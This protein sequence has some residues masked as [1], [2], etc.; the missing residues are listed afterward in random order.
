ML[1]ADRC[2]Q[3][4][5]GLISHCFDTT[6]RRACF[7]PTRRSKRNPDALAGNLGSVANLDLIKSPG[8]KERRVFGRHTF[9]HRNFKV[10]AIGFCGGEPEVIG[11]QI[12]ERVNA[13][14]RVVVLSGHLPGKLFPGTPGE[15]RCRIDDENCACQKNPATQ[16]QSLNQTVTG[17]LY[18]AEAGVW[19][20]SE[21]PAT[22]TIILDVTPFGSAL[23]IVKDPSG[24][25]RAYVDEQSPGIAR[26]VNVNIP[27]S[28][29]YTI[30]V[31]N[32]QN[33]QV[34]YTLTVQDPL[35]PPPP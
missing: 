21:G 10:I 5:S 4:S 14:R 25:D 27:T 34:N 9:N 23:L 17:T 33:E 3:Y 19:I 29:D 22:V 28:G 2:C 26:L 15:Q 1:A 30:W 24:V 6:Q 32:A 12:L 11:D 16:N 35:T 18:Q 8:Q 7:V 20:F 13:G 31:R